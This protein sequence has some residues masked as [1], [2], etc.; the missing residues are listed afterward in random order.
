MIPE[1]SLP[2]LGKRKCIYVCGFLL[3][4][5]VDLQGTWLRFGEMKEP[6]L[7]CLMNIIIPREVFLCGWYIL[8]KV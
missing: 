2:A 1:P 8:D 7:Y 6:R 4:E 3:S 5:Q